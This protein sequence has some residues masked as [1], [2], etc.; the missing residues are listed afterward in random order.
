METKKKIKIAF[1]RWWTPWNMKYF[2]ERFPFMANNY[3]FVESKNPDY[4]MYSVF[5][6]EP[7]PKNCTKI[8]YTAENAAPNMSECDYAISFRRDMAGKHFRLPNYAVRYNHC[9]KHDLID[10]VRN[11]RPRSHLYWKDRKFCV[12]LH[13]RPSEPRDSFVKEL[14]KYKKVDCPGIVHRNMNV[15]IPKGGDAKIN[16]FKKYKFAMAFEN[17]RGNGYVTEKLTDAMMAGCIP[18][19]WGDP[20]VKLDFNT[21]SFIEVLDYGNFDRAIK[22]IK[23]IDSDASAAKKILA[24]PWINYDSWILLN[25][26]KTE[27]FIR[28][29]FG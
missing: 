1:K 21:R 12:F 22:R 11:D 13:R 3:D 23:N 9:K 20:Q 14:S 8:F 27:N 15:K 17:S 29:I 26:H 5:G 24:Q 25:N 6:N 28:R 2:R 7:L 18:I 16:F 19:Y 4:V 10:L